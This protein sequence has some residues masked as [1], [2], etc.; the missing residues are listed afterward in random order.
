MQVF[1][2]ETQIF[3]R[4]TSAISKNCTQCSSFCYSSRCTRILILRIGYGLIYFLEEVVKIFLVSLCTLMFGASVAAAYGGGGSG[5]PP[6]LRRYQVTVLNLTKGQ[7]LTPPV[8][9]LHKRNSRLVQLGNPASAGL[10]ELAQDGATASLKAEFDANTSVVSTAVG[11]GV[12][13]PGEKS[14][15]VIETRSQ[16]HLS[17]SVFSMLARTNDAF[18]KSK[19]EYLYSGNTQLARVYDAGVEQNTE[20]CAHIP[21]PPC[22][23]HNVGTDG[24]EGFVRPHEGLHLSRD[25]NG[26]RD[27]FANVAAQVTLKNL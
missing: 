20:D 16:H 25:L 4:H 8:V 13:M 3:C 1:C 14:E 17:I 27:T 10:A 18:I 22:G 2:L 6:P 9:V 15:I 21:A 24:G 26:Q 19:I 5:K 23:N 11:N 7:P 12:I